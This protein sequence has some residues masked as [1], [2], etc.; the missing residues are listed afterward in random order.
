MG[1]GFSGFPE[2]GTKFLRSLKRNN[3]REWFQPRKHLYEQHLKAPMLELV[4]ALN[5]GLSRFA[6]DYVTDPP[7]AIFRIY[8][9]TRFSADKTPYKTH[10]AASFS[11]RGPER[12][13]AGGFYFSVAPDQI[14]VAAGIYHPEPD[15]MLAIRTH[16][17]E[18]HGELRRLL[19]NRKTRL[20]A[21]ELQGDALTRAPKGFDP[22]HPA[23]GW[24]KM[25]D[26]ILDVTLYGSLAT[27]P[28]LHDEILSRFRAMA[29]V[30][31]YLNRPLVAR[32]PSRDLLEVH[33]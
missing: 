27:S 32:K 1:I 15:T 5:T 19:A 8:R 10:I 24:I 31:D 33:W 26:W 4:A 12:L 6:P 3:R 17:A 21:G 22:A 13:K 9:D 16:I 29:P 7:K 11:R 30:I 25:K 14:E 2:E 18:T 23:I 28:K 20:L